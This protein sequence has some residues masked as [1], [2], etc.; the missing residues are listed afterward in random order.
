MDKLW[1]EVREAALT[2]NPKKMLA[3]LFESGFLEGIENKM[4]KKWPR[5]PPE[6]LDNFIIAAAIDDLYEKISKGELVT[7]PGGYIYKVAQ[8]KAVSYI[9]CHKEMNTNLLNKE[10]Q[11]AKQYNHPFVDQPKEFDRE[12]CL[13]RALIEVRLLLPR[14]GKENVQKV[15]GYVFDCIEAR[16]YDV[17]P[18]EMA[19][20]LGLSSGVVRVSLTR[21]FNRIKSIALEID[22]ANQILSEAESI[23]DLNDEEEVG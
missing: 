9:Q 20:A 23:T 21:G 7:N 10:V 12:F 6:E 17:K 15:M 3:L 19:E 11:L 8:F 1:D 13:E 22:L 2:F 5:I 14:L 4:R 16:R 18:A